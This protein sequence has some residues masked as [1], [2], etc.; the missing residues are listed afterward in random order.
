MD[1]LQLID[2]IRDFLE[3]IGLKENMIKWLRD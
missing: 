2:K 1:R 3:S